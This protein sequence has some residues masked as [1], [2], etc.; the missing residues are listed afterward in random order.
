MFSK[1]LI[2]AS[3]IF[4]HIHKSLHLHII[5]LLIFNEI[6]IAGIQVVYKK[7]GWA[8]FHFVQWDRSATVLIHKIE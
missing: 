1:Y 4:T 6:L 2:T 3:F 8:S 7:H 5:I